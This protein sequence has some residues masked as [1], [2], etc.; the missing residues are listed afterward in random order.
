MVL[1]EDIAAFV[2]DDVDRVA[3]RYRAPVERP[4]IGSGRRRGLTSDCIELL[5]FADGMSPGF[6]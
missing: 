2:L 4:R 3:A 5:L 6:I 1:L